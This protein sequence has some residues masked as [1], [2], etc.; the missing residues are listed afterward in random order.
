[1]LQMAVTRITEVGRYHM[2]QAENPVWIA[3]ISS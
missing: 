2:Q 3:T 1:M